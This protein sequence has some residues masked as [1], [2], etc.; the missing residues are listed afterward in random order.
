MNVGITLNADIT[1]NLE[2]LLE[3]IPKAVGVHF[4][5]TMHWDNQEAN[6]IL[7]TDTSLCLGLTFIY[8]D[9]G[10]TYAISPYC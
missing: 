1:R 6:L 5:D 4:I 9:H 2:W 7:W 10:F 3:V 8:A